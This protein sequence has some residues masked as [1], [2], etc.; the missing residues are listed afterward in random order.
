[1]KV[2]ELIQQLEKL[3]PE[4][5]VI[6]NFID[7]FGNWYTAGIGEIVDMP[8]ASFIVIQSTKNHFKEKEDE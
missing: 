8:K 2:K 4:K 7:N 5:G 1:M 6:L 3:N